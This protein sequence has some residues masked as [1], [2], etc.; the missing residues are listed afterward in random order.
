MVRSMPAAR[1]IRNLS[2]PGP[3]LVVV[4][5]GLHIAAQR[6]QQSN[7]LGQ[8]FA[9]VRLES[10]LQ[11]VGR[12]VV[13]RGVEIEIR[14]DLAKRQPVGVV[15]GE[16]HGAATTAASARTSTARRVALELKRD[17]PSLSG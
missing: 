7:V 16:L 9:A 5:P 8:L 17:A 3:D 2:N 15:I 13:L 4:E 1:T 10:G 12:A 14:V 6:A 11:P